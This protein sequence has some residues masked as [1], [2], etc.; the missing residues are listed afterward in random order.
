DSAEIGSPGV[1]VYGYDG[2]LMQPIAPPSLD[3]MLGPEH[4]PSPDYVLGPKHPP[5]PVE[6]PYL[7]EPEYPEYLAPSDNEAPL[8]D[9]PLPVDASPIAASPG[10]V[11]DF[12]LEEDLEDDHADYPADGGDGDDD[13]FDDDDDDVT[14]DEDEDPI[15]DEEDNEE[16]EEHLASADSSA[17]PI[18]DHVLLAGDTEALETVRPKPS[19]SASMEACIARHVALLSP[20]LPVLSPPLPL[21]SPL[22]TSPTDTRASLGYRAVGFRMRA[23]LSSTS[24]MTDIPEADV[25]P[26][27]RACLTTPAPGFED[28]IVDTLMEIAPTTLDGVDQRVIELDTIVRQM[29]DEDRPDHRRTAMLLDREAM[30]ASEAWAGSKDRS[31]SIAAHVRIL[32]AHVVALIAQTS[33]LQIRLTTTLGRIEI[34]KARDPEPQEGPVEAG[35]SWLSCMV[36]DVVMYGC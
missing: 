36:I 18:V 35:S 17:V 3:Y 19:M 28:E 5:S 32:E 34:L 15:E 8:E 7:P 25:P 14:D 27:K 22:T 10:Y 30:Y 20:P 6:I 13:P 29:T 11:A 26:R 33:S 23:L 21:P 12:D 1:I 4:P 24:R 31:S 2:L 9:Q 16:E